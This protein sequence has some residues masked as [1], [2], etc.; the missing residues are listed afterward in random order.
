MMEL[1]VDNC[2][3]KMVS[4]PIYFTAFVHP[5]TLSSQVP[6]WDDIA[7]AKPSADSQGLSQ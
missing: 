4:S 3:I 6:G 1:F 7:I 2:T 5:A